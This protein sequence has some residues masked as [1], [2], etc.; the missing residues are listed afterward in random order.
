MDIFW[1]PDWH[2]NN[3]GLSLRQKEISGIF[4]PLSI[5]HS[6]WTW[7][8]KRWLYRYHSFPACSYFWKRYIRRGPTQRSRSSK[9]VFGSDGQMQ[10]KNPRRRQG[11]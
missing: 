11:R 3:D 4:W 7:R 10:R 2:Q 5:Y 8:R 9:P 1:T 6:F